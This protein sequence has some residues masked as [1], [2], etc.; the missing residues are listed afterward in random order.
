LPAPVPPAVLPKMPV[1]TALEVVPDCRDSVEARSVYVAAPDWD[2]TE[3]PAAYRAL[4]YEHVVDRLR[5]TEG[6][7][8]VYRDGENNFAKVC[9]QYT[10][11]ISVSGFKQG[12][13]VTRAMLGPVGM[14]VGTTQMKFDTTLNDASGSLDLRKQVRGTIRGESESTGV[15]DSVAKT[16]AKQYAGILKDADRKVIAQID[17]GRKR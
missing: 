3:V 4:V 11:H 16:I 17:T 10:I 2:Q 1:R 6:A 12:S 5:R 15:A 7:G 14:F 9:P 13:Q 8:R